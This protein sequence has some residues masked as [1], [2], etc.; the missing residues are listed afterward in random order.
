MNTPFPNSYQLSI[1]PWL[2][3]GL[4]AYLI[5][6]YWDLAQTGLLPPVI[7]AVSSYVQLP[8][9]YHTLCVRKTLFPVAT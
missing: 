8:C 4:Q 7:M 3:L 2:G 1:A 6:L 9:I 5:S